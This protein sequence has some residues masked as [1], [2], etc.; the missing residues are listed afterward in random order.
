MPN[1]LERSAILE[2]S[3]ALAATQAGGTLATMHAEDGTP[4][5]TFVLFHLRPT[6]EVLFGSGASPQHVRNMTATPE[7]SFLIDNRE[8][9]KNDWTAFNRLVVE[10]HSEEIEPGDPRYADW[11]AEL[12]AK[13]RMAGYFTEHG[14]LYCIRPR[15]LILMKGFQPDRYVVDFEGE[16]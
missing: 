11:L 10:G 16:E 6:G 4:Y 15:R 13:S 8:V 2:E 1:P 7:V 14:K 5:V 9:V 12:T 3:S